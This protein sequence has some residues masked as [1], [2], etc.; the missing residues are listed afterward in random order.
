MTQSLRHVVIMGPQGA[1]KGT[2]AAAVA[3]ELGLI[4]LSTGD[5]FRQV[6][7][8]ESDLAREVRG[9]V[10]QGSLVPDDLTA[11]MLMERIDETNQAESDMA[12]ALIDGFPRNTNQAKVL[13]QTLDARGDQ[14]VSVV[15]VDVPRDELMKRLT[16]RLVCKECGA[17]YHKSFNPPA[18]EGICDKCGGELMQRSDDTPEAVTKRLEI[19][20]EQTEPVLDY[21]RDAGLLIDI[22]GNQPIDDV[23]VSIL[24]R[25]RPAFGAA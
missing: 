21:Y 1:G 22:D 11:R 16:G 10:D 17:T 14:I 15:H 24:A 23:T 8:E 6:M 13:D 5:I 18:Q 19:Y 4:H 2:Q 25:L 7:S 20:Y 9:Y 3:P 12:G